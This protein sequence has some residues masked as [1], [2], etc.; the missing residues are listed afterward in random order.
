METVFDIVQ[1]VA[2]VITVGIT[3]FTTVARPISN[4]SKQLAL[5]NAQQV[6]TNVALKDVT[7]NLRELIVENRAEHAEFRD[8]LVDHEKRIYKME[9]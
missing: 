5:S 7:D 8:K 9:G 2:T 4:F 6:Q 1:L 3:L